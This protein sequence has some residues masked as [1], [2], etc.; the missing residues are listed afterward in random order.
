MGLL[1]FNPCP[2]NGLVGSFQHQ[3]L[4]YHFIFDQRNS[5][6]KFWIM[7]DHACYLFF[8][9]KIEQASLKDDSERHSQPIQSK[10][11]LMIKIHVPSAKHYT[12]NFN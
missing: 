11:E 9:D 5:E 7:V 3:Q 8:I 1:P 6:I 4:K 10:S 12:V 2:H